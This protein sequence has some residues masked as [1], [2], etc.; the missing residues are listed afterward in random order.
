MQIKTL[1]GSLSLDNQQRNIIETTISNFEKFVQPLLASFSQGILHGDIGLQNVVQNRGSRTAYGIIDFGDCMHNCH[2]FELATLI[3]GFLS[4]GD[5]KQEIRATSPLVG[6]YN[7]AFPLSSEE[8][9]CLYYIVLARMC[10]AAVATELNLQVDPGNGYLREVVQRSWTAAQV[11]FKHPKQKVDKLWT[12][13]I[14][15]TTKL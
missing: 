4:R 13:A 6:G 15:E 5:L 2:I 9:G 12:D 10:V 3:H 8:L 14:R 7:C 1:L 11:L